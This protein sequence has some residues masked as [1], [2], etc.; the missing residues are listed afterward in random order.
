MTHWLNDISRELNGKIY[1]KRKSQPSVVLKARWH[2][3]F[4]ES[5]AQYRQSWVD[6]CKG[7]TKQWY[8]RQETLEWTFGTGKFKGKR[9]ATTI[10]RDIGYITW[11]LENQPKGK[12]AKQI[13]HF[14]TRYPEILEQ[15]KRK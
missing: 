2:K 9:I 1:N 14:I 5:G 7:K 8:Q 13:I 11:V 6:Y 15:V 12:T 10:K 3:D 4:L